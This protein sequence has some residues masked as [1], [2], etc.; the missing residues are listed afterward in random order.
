MRKKAIGI[1]PDSQ[2]YVCVLVNTEEERTKVKRFSSTKNGLNMFLKWMELQGDV[3]IAIEGK[4]GYSTAMENMLQE[5]EIPFYSFT[6]S[7]VDKYRKSIV[8]QQKNNA[9][10]AEATALLGLTQESTKRL[11]KNRHKYFVDYELRMITR[12]YEART[13]EINQNTNR[14]WKDLMGSCSDLFLFAYGMHPDFELS[15]DFMDSKG[16]L[17]LLEAKRIREWQN[18][19][20]KQLHDIMCGNRFRNFEQIIA[21]IK[22]IALSLS[23]IPLGIE[24]EL[25]MKAK[26]I[27]HLMEMKKQTVHVLEELSLSRPA[28]GELLSIKGIGVTTASIIAAEIIN[29]LRFPNNNRLASY[30]GLVKKQYATGPDRKNPRMVNNY[31]FNKRLKNAFMTAA[32]SYVIHNPDSHLAGYYRNLIKRGMKRTEAIKRVARALVRIIFRKLLQFENNKKSDNVLANNKP[33]R[34]NIKSNNTLS[35]YKYTKYIKQVE[36]SNKIK[37]KGKIKNS[38]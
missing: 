4:Q 21:N 14:L 1:D 22:K 20:D 12:S 19:T 25:Q 6:P 30:A 3:V 35:Q 9:I 34:L 24:V 28:V 8:S 27:L 13:K 7:T 10:D 18:L 15:K 38:A 11:E 23:N 16:F 32:K 26:H 29:I 17:Q 33:N 36:G 31:L 2:G 5:K 37:K